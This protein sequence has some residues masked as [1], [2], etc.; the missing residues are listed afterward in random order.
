MIEVK[1][2]FSRKELL[3]FGP[4]FGLFAGFLGAV[5]M[6]RF[7]STGAAKGIWIVSAVLI[8]IYYLFPSLRKGIFTGWMMTVFPIGWI[9]SHALLAL[10]FYFVVYPIGLL[11]RLFGHDALGRRFDPDAGSYWMDCETEEDP[12]RYF[13]QF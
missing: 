12:K 11:M 7:D 2:S 1:K 13:R 3:W 10:V 5:A 9:L 8:G 6:V 4:L